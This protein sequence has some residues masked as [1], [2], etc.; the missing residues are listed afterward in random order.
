MTS[1]EPRWGPRS[2]DSVVHAGVSSATGRPRRVTRTAPD[3]ARLQ[4]LEDRQAVRLELGGADAQNV[5]HETA[6]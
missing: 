5:I 3:P 6:R 1:T 4:I 2:V